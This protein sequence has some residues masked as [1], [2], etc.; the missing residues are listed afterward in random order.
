MGGSSSRPAVGEDGQPE[1]PQLS[2]WQMM[3][4]GYAV[5]DTMQH[6]G[7]G[8][9]VLMKACLP[10]RRRGRLLQPWRL[11]ARHGSMLPCT[12]PGCGIPPKQPCAC[13][14]SR[15][16]AAVQELVNAIIRPP[17]AEYEMAHLGPAS[18]EFCDR[19]FRRVDFQVSEAGG[20]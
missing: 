12:L 9:W 20:F 11:R 2:Y 7:Q 16:V 8:V 10:A 19:R 3:R 5:S 14:E 1:E 15:P 6:V 17:R 4:L 18:F 13:A